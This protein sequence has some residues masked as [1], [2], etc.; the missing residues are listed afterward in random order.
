MVC[1]SDTA[2]AIRDALSM[3]QVIRFYGYT[4]NRAGFICCPFHQ[5]KTPSLKIYTDGFCCFGC[6]RRGS[7]IDFV[8]EL[9]GCSFTDA[10]KRLDT[11]FTLGLTN[12]PVDRDAINA[13]RRQQI[14]AKAKKDAEIREYRQKIKEFRECNEIVQRI[15]PD[16][17]G[18]IPDILADALKRLPALEYWFDTHDFPL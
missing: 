4:P 1:H 17:F 8:M 15:Q 5:E 11:D 14:R 6:Q 18:E 13:R 7:V 3:D 12:A 16:K 10:L 9:F 2:G